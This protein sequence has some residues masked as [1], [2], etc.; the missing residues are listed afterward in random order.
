MEVYDRAHEL[1]RALSRSE[2]YGDYR[3][4][5]AKLESN[6]TNLQMLRDFR[7]RQLQLEMDLLAGKEPDSSLR[8]ALEESYRIISLNPTITAYLAAEE[9][10]ARLLADIQKILFD[11]IPEWGKDMVDNVDNEK[12]TNL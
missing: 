9:R 8:Q 10:L 2:E 6:E 7:R 12:G 11:A 5:K 3:L 4:A 1:A